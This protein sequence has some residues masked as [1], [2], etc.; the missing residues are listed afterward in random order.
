MR[1]PFSRGEKQVK[2]VPNQDFLQ[3]RDRFVKGQVYRVPISLARYF[4]RNGWIEGSLASP[5]PAVLDID[6]SVLGHN[7]G[8]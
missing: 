1:N 7:G 2:I 3:E 8:F 6:D 4:E 5:P